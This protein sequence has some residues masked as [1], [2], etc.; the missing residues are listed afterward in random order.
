MRNV[1]IGFNGL[2]K[3]F[4]SGLFSTLMHIQVPYKGEVSLLADRI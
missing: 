2:R 3:V 1:C 4:Y